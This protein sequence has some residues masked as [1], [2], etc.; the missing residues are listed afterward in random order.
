MHYESAW[1]ASRPA[2]LTG[3]LAARKGN[4][5]SLP[6]RSDLLPGAL[7]LLQADRESRKQRPARLASH[8][9]LLQSRRNSLTRDRESRARNR[10]QL[11]RDSALRSGD[12]NTAGNRPVSLSYAKTYKSAFFESQSNTRSHHV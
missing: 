7:V 5:E 6:S 12:L 10:D 8:L 9:D 11:T 1:L 3:H 2:L 4:W